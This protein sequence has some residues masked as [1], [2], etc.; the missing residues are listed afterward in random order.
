M[1]APS[2]RV[3]EGVPI[4]NTL[5]LWLPPDGSSSRRSRLLWL[6]SVSQQ[7]R[8]LPRWRTFIVALQQDGREEE[9][10][11]TYGQLEVDGI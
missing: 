2:A 5:S 10:S 11:R 3:T 6:L 1:H 4:N 8:A 7:D 9:P